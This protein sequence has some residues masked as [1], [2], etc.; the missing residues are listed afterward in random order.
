M[1]FADADQRA[2]QGSRT[3]TAS[4][5]AVDHYFSDDCGIFISGVFANPMSAYNL[6]VQLVSNQN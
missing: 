1:A 3:V 6:L 2:T 4:V 5:A